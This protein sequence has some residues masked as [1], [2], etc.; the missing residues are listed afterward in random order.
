MN[1]SIQTPKAFKELYTPSRYKVF[2]GGRGGAKST[3][4]ADA[5]LVLGGMR[6]LRI[7]CAREIQKSIKES[8]YSLLESRIKNH[9]MEASYEVLGN[10]IRGVNGTRFFF[11]GLWRNIDSI[12]SIDGVDICWVEEANTVSEDSWKK[13]I[14]TIRKPGSE[15][16]ASFNPE[17]KTDAAYQRFVINPP[18]GAIVRKVSWRD[19]PW[20]TDEL[21]AEMDHLKS[22][23][24]EEYL[25]VWE[26]ELKQFADGAI[27]GKQ[28]KQARKEHRITV[29]PVEPGI[30]V[31]TFWDLGRNDTTA[32]W[33][34]QKVG[35]QHRF[36]DY[37]ESR[38]VDLDHY[39]R[40]LKEKDYLYGEHFLPHDAEVIVLGSNNQS[41]V[42][43][44]ESGG[45]KPITVVPRTPNINEGIEQTRKVFASCWF[46]Q[47]RCERGLDALANYQYI[48]DEKYDTFRQTPLHNWASNGADAF[49][50]FA[51][52]WADPTEFKPRD[53]QNESYTSG[54]WMM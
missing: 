50:Q 6:P 29:V 45:V 21:K 42:V 26:G 33:F 15:I 53:I 43:I 40:V 30:P 49:R 10:E 13:L 1:S 51:Q 24:E 20:F 4:F 2:W 27:Y 52:G 16:W 14:P 7:L 48:F 18:P 54:G 35:L 47:D 37:Y 44:L 11:E 3:A 36:F 46:D 5:L 19:N 12:K 31:N 17:L 38:L 9:G 32:I 39:I 22:T 28:L 41:R 34:H 23:D 8:V 25:H